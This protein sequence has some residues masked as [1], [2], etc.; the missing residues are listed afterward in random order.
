[1]AR[2][3]WDD[4]TSNNLSLSKFE[5]KRRQLK[6]KR[7]QKLVLVDEI[8]YE[9]DDLWSTIEF[10]N[11]EERRRLTLNYMNGCLPAFEHWCKTQKAEYYIERKA[12]MY[13]TTQLTHHRGYWSGSRR[14]DRRMMRIQIRAWLPDSGL[15]GW[16]KLDQEIAGA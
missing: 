12:T 2:V 15:V 16:Y 5:L 10:Y 4:R 6:R 9:S 7:W 8:I 13:D 14:P 3:L 1:M 11:T